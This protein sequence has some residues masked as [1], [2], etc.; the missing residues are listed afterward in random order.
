MELKGKKVLVTGGA[1]FIGFYT[2]NAL[3][4]RG[5]EVIVIDNLVTGREENLNPRAGFYRLNI[6]S[7]EVEN[8]FERERPELVY[9]FA[10]NV[11]VPKSVENPLID[12]DSIAGSVNIFQNAKKYGVEKIIFSSS[13][14][15]Y[16]NTKNLPARETEPVS[17]ISPYVVSKNAV[18][19]YL[20]FF[21]VAHGLPYVVLR[22]AAVYGPGQVTGA[23]AD[24][25]RKLTT[26]EQAQIWG[27]GSKTRDYVYIDDAVRANLLALK[28]P[29]DYPCP[30]FNVGT[31][32]ETTLNALYW[33]ITKIL[34]KEAR[35]IYLPDRPGEQMRYAL[36]YSKIKAVLKWQ[37]RIALDGGLKRTVE[38]YLD[39]HAD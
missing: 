32:V 1:G 5:A 30:V 35:P 26:G 33:K 15:L 34:N 9:H 13:G 38:T 20:E 21:R 8:V 25:I 36:D 28:L 31:G 3:L 12:M 6:A 37:P 23:M 14:F 11:L 2:T 39:A 29:F 22:Y 7:P 10:F 27:D 4:K 17:P 18:E 16:G 19:N 24:Y